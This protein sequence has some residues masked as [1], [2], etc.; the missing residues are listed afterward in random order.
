MIWNLAHY[1]FCDFKDYYANKLPNPKED[2][3]LCSV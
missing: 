3:G 1:L 2:K